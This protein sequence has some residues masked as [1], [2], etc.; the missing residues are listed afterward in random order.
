MMNVSEAIQIIRHR[1][2]TAKDIAGT[3]SNADTF[4]DL[5]LAIK[6]LKEMQS[7]QILQKRLDDMFGDYVSLKTVVDELEFKLKNPDDPHPVNAK[8]LTYKDA[9]DWDAY[10]ALGSPEEIKRLLNK[11]EK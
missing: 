8:I 2:S 7:Y 5:E 11:N 6:A 10:R 9:A 1:I 4:E 3:G